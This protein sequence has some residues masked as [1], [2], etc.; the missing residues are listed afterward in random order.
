MQFAAILVAAGSGERAGPGLPKAWRLLAGKPVARWSVEALLAAGAGPLIV[1]VAADMQRT[2]QGALA[3]LPVILINGGA[4]RAESVR[5]GLACASD[6]APADLKVLIHD[7]ARPFLTRRHVHDLLA[8]LEAADGALPA[9]PVAD[10][11]KRRG[12]VG[13]ITVPRDGL[14]R[15]QT[16]QAF[17]LQ[18]LIVAHAAWSGADEPTDD[19][20]VIEAAGGVIALTAGD[21]LLMKLTYPEDFEM[22][23][24][25]AG[26]QR[27]TRVGQGFDALVGVVPA[28]DLH[29]LA[30][31]G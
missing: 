19:A 3:G 10:T 11:L 2:A 18:K 9:L 30:C 1:V 27:L 24:R 29:R 28:V 12:D 4:T 25:L 22:A 21:P 8:A 31:N 5:A 17:D 16:P 7:A 6:G 26:G 14:W 15:A 20:A 13:T 23:E